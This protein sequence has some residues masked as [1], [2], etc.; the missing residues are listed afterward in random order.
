MGNCYTI[1]SKTCCSAHIDDFSR[2]LD[3][4]IIEEPLDILRH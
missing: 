3:D 4:E 1:N 2:V